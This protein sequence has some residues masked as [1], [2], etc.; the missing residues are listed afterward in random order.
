MAELAKLKA[1][2]G[3][4]GASRMA[5]GLILQAAD[6]SHRAGIPKPHF[7]PGKQ[8]ISSGG[9]ACRSRNVYEHASGHAA[10]VSRRLAMA[11]LGQA[12]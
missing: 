11:K 4:G 8:V 10:I 12:E 7:V 6:E 2:V 1:K 5:A 9:A 3:H